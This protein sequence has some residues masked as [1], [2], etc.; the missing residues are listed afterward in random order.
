[1]ILVRGG[2]VFTP[3]PVGRKELLLAGRS[4]VG[5]LDPDDPLVAAVVQ[6]ST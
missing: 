5:V 6:A 1:M 2:K 4:I 3:D